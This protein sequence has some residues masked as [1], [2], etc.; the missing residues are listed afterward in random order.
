MTRRRAA[1][2]AA[3]A[4]VAAC[5]ATAGTIALDVAARRPAGAHRTDPTIVTRVDEVV[6]PL[7]DVVLAVRAGVADQLLLVNRGT[8]PVFV[9]DSAGE[10]F[11]RIGPDRVDARVD[12]PDWPGSLNPFGTAARPTPPT[13]ATPAAPRGWEP[14][15]RGA[16]WAWFDHRL[17]EHDLA[18]T[19][20]MRRARRPVRL[21]EWTV[22]LLRGGTLHTAY[23]HVEYRPVTGAFRSRATEWP[24]GAEV[25]VLD[26][27][28]P[29]VRMRWRGSGTLLVRGA[30]GEP[31]AR[32]AAT[33]VEVNERSATWRD[34]RALRGQPLAP[35]DERAPRWT[36]Q[37][38]EPVLTWLDRRLAYATGLPP[39]DVA[40]RRE[41]T[42][43][44]EWELPAEVD[45][46]PVRL[47][48]E[49]AWH[50]VAAEHGEQ[51]H[52]RHLV[53]VAAALA[54]AGLVTIVAVR[55]RGSRR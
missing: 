39:D 36:R 14:V 5:L 49:T 50:P 29:A 35:T 40:R 12:S 46:R 26:G 30:E 3:A 28:V 11:L 43:L 7:T 13:A 17:H 55:V 24:Q 16:S 38:T 20:P 6:P 4:L 10:P 31:F 34:D 8:L 18:V 48:G 52:A 45:G 54:A 37:G 22:P 27:R 44:V 23:G 51:S 42:T 2:R 1:A 32:F 41:P 15:G 53:A 9:L 33:G 47:A 25:D 21:G 19:V